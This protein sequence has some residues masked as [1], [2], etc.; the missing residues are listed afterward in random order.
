MSGK[1][2]GHLNFFVFRCFVAINFVKYINSTVVCADS[3]GIY[4]MTYDYV[5]R[6]FLQPFVR[7]LVKKKKI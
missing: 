2:A 6:E 3:D 1:W 5:V 4:V 7:L